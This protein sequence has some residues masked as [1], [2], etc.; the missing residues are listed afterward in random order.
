[1]KQALYEKQVLVAD[2]LHVPRE[3]FETIAELAG[4]S[5]PN[6]EPSE[7]VL[8][9]VNQGTYFYWRALHRTTK[10]SVVDGGD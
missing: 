3:E 2:I 10:L 1:M 8:A 7:L 4:E 6:K 9:A 5:E